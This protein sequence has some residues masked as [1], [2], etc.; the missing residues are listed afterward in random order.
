[1]EW[2]REIGPA[3]AD[4]EVPAELRRVAEALALY[5][6]SGDVVALSGD[7]GAGKTTF[8]RALI[9]A[10][11]GRDGE[12]VASPTFPILIGY[13]APRMAIAHY[14]LYRIEAPEA[15]DELDVEEQRERG[16]VLVEWPERAGGRL[17]AE[18]FDVTLAE[19]PDKPGRRLTIRADGEQAA[20][21]ARFAALLEFVDAL[22]PP[23]PQARIAYLQG[24]ASARRYARLTSSAG[25]ALVMDAPRQ[26][27]GPLIRDGLPYSRIAHLAEDV[28]PV[29]ALAETLS[30]AGLSTPAILARD[31]DRGFLLIEDL[32]D[33]VFGTLVAAGADQ[34][35]LWRAA[36]D[37]LVH[38]ARMPPPA[39][40]P[41]A[42]AGEHVLAAYDARAMAIETELLVD[43]LWPLLFGTPASASDR[44]HSGPGA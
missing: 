5:L 39:A 10:L 6:R 23:W 32:G 2:A 34:A 38:L 20:R 1:M 33:R 29:V 13:T 40:L 14:D 26:P 37:A 41:V 3:T 9:R 31:L 27:D 24:D 17:P 30:K 15:L 11:L 21:L 18:R 25:S 42:G 19:I 36:V 22:P 35:E 4:D 7:L 8:A 43:W 16:L 12:E 44:A 28:R